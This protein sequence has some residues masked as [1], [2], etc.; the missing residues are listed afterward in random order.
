MSGLNKCAFIGRVGS[1]PE[2]RSMSNGNEVMNLRIA[3]SEKWTDKNTG[4]KRESTTWI[5]I[6]VFNDRIISFARQYVHKGDLV[7][8]EGAFSVRKWQDQSGN[9][10]YATE[11]VLQ[12]FRGELQ[13]LDSKGE[14]RADGAGTYANKDMGDEDAPGLDDSI[15][16]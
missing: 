5:P 8:V 9:D 11:I 1:D 12:R 15:P 13:M 7:Y 3:V 10:R 14:K 16:F 4:E 2:V 6:V